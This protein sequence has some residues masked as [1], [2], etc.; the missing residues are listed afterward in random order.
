MPPAYP[1]PP[2]P[3]HSD[4]EPVTETP[5]STI[6]TTDIASITIAYATTTVASNG[7][8][9]EPHPT[10]LASIRSTTPHANSA[11]PPTITNPYHSVANLPHVSITSDGADKHDLLPLPTDYLDWGFLGYASYAPDA[12]YPFHS[13]SETITKTPLSTINTT[14]IASIAIT[15]ADATSAATPYLSVADINYLHADTLNHAPYIT[16]YY[17]TDTFFAF[18]DDIADIASIAAIPTIDAITVAATV[19]FPTEP[20]ST[21]PTSRAL[22][23]RIAPIPAPLPRGTPPRSPS[24]GRSRPAPTLMGPREAGA[25]V[26]PGLF[27]LLS[28]QTP[29]APAP[30]LR[31]PCTRATARAPL[32]G[33]PLSP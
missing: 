26:P 11:K 12:P 14:D 32:R 4:L 23:P 22:R 13:D 21:K 28:P 20:A 7:L 33:A 30:S 6:N 16:D 10:P 8:A 19:N 9:I 1:A 31:Q 5:L 18:R 24:P 27:F 29:S 2:V 17:D 25:T 3:F 15:F